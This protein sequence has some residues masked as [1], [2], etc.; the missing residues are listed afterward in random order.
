MLPILNHLV[1]A[2][3]SCQTVAT[4]R[5]TQ[6]TSSAGTPAG[7]LLEQDPYSMWANVSPDGLTFDSSRWGHDTLM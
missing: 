1:G 3:Q 2:V 6:S 5:R 4:T 7:R